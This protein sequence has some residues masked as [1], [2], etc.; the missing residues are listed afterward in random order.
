MKIK[1]RERVISIYTFTVYVNMQDC[2]EMQNACFELKHLIS[3]IKNILFS[4][5]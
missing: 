2:T 1:L 5:F 3:H 4:Y